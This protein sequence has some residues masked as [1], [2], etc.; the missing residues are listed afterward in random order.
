M[1]SKSK[2]NVYCARITINVDFLDHRTT[3]SYMYRPVVDTRD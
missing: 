3:E 1:N 2:R